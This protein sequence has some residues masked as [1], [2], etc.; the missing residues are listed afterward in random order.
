MGFCAELKIG[1]LHNS[2]NRANFLAETTI[3]ALC[4]VNV[5]PSSLAIAIFPF[6]CFNGKGLSRAH[7]LCSISV[8][9]G[10]ESERFEKRGGADTN[11]NKR[12]KSKSQREREVETG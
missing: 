5:I 3:D 12:I 9:G 4:H 7:L 10:S 1:T 6:F 11:T 2:I 8:S